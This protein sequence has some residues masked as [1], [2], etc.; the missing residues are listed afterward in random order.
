MAKK[1]PTPRVLRHM[2][3]DDFRQ[4]VGQKVSLVGCYGPNILLAHPPPAAL[5]KL[6]FFFQ[7]E[8]V[9]AGARFAFRLWYPKKTG[10]RRELFATTEG[11]LKR[12]KGRGYSQLSVGFSPFILR[13]CGRYEGK[14][15]IEGARGYTF[16]FEVGLQEGV[17]P[18]S[19]R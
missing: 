13:V 11:E 3:C 2:L 16:A 10:K 7:I 14:L 4:E 5:S 18:S 15:A 9:T 17:E 8:N 1:K 19:K 6:C 12:P